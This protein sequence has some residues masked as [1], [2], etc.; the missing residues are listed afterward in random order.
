MRCFIAISLPE[1]IRRQLG[2]IQSKL[3]KFNA[4][5]GWTRPEG[6][7]LTLKFLG[8]IGEEK[9]ESIKSALQKIT[10]QHK[11]FEIE[12]GGTG[13]F[14]DT[15]RPRVL[16]VGMTKGLEETTSLA[17]QVESKMEELGFPKEERKF[18]PHLTLGRVKSPKNISQFTDTFLNTMK[19]NL[20]KIHV[21]H[22]SLYQSVLKPTGA[23]YSVLFQS[24]LRS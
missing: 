24:S 1:E 11:P 18:N 8:E 21:D 22:I 13:V 3:K 6:I 15:R 17:E 19:P 16:W 20:G 5:I 14:P 2:E 4:D 10:S 23:E 7:H 9:I 12:I